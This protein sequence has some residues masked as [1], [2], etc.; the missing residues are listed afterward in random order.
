MA[1]NNQQPIITLS[2]I[3]RDLKSLGLQRRDTIMLHSSVKSIGWVVGGPD[4]VLQAII[5][6]LGDKG[7]LMMLAGWEDNPYHLPEWPKDKQLA[8]LEECPPFDPATSRANRKWSIL[9]EYLRTR[10]GAL[11]SSHPEGSFVAV[12]PLAEHITENHLWQYGYGTGSPLAKLCDKDGKVLIIGA[13]LNT[14]TL[15]HYAE[16]LADVSD[17]RVI[18]YKMPVMRQGKR[19]WV[20]L[21]EYDTSRGIVDWQGEDYFAIIGREYLLS[22][23]GTSGKVGE[24]QSYLFD[25]NDLVKF[26]VRWMERTFKKPDLT[27][28]RK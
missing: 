26:A 22:G 10:P 12:G 16:F 1:E 23:K 13:P 18:H 11:R 15:L 7:T 2:R 27:N 8:Y 5:N 6:I 9:N 28:H 24:A 3:V 19:V 21:E 17:K 4:T 14:I 20:D 25:A